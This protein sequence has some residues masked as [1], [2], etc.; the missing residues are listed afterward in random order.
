MSY[1][2]IKESL[3]SLAIILLLTSTVKAESIEEKMAHIEE[4]LAQTAAKQKEVDA[5]YEETAAKYK[6]AFPD[7]EAN[8]YDAKIE[9]ARQEKRNQEK[10]KASVEKL[11]EEEIDLFAKE[12]EE[13]PSSTTKVQEPLRYPL[14]RT[15]Q[16]ETT[17][18]KVQ[19]RGRRPFTRSQNEWGK[20][21]LYYAVRTNAET[22]SFAKEEDA[23]SSS[24]ETTSSSTTSSSSSSSASPEEVGYT[25]TTEQN[26]FVFSDNI[27]NY[28]QIDTNSSSDAIV[29]CLEKVLKD[30]STGSEMAKYNVNQMYRESMQDTVFHAVAD[31][32][33]YKN[34]S[35]GFEANVLVPLQEKSAKSTDE[36]GDIEVLTLVDMENYKIL[37]KLIQA[38][39]TSLSVQSFNDFGSFEMNSE[40]ISD[41]SEESNAASENK[42]TTS[43]SS[44]TKEESSDKETTTQK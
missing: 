41:I 35:A 4:S 1:N 20:N 42:S 36:R 12:T 15:P 33:K 11:T 22:L 13:K 9:K 43:A 24:E 7:E 40:A 23:A 17:P 6:E 18:Q 27:A 29:A 2:I 37:N 21:E 26:V 19:P 30:K 44:S 28:C 8:T 16:Y 31:S 3:K 39:A 10:M 34:D 38:Y 5:L 25:G 32:A 14:E